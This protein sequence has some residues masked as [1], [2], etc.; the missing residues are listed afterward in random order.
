MTFTD[1]NNLQEFINR[2]QK[3][4]TE[5]QQDKIDEIKAQ[6]NTLMNNLYEEIA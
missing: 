1:P 6:V 4:M 2:R 5:K 3:E